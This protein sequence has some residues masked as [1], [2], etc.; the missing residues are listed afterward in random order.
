MR[1]FGRP[2]ASRWSHEPFGRSADSE[3]ADRWQVAAEGTGWRIRDD[4][5]RAVLIRVASKLF[6]I[7]R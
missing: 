2:D 4:S 6:S 3:S 7:P 1:Y 5:V